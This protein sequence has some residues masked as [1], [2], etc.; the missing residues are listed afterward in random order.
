MDTALIGWMPVLVVTTIDD[1]L[2]L[3]KHV[4]CLPRYGQVFSLVLLVHAFEW[5]R[6][7]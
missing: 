6:L 7:F 3:F 4:E 2:V 1:E 5:Q